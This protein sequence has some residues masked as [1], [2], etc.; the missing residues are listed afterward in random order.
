VNRLDIE[1]ELVE[2]L[3]RDATG[4]DALPLLAFTLQ[5]LFND[6]APE[7][8]LTL[9]HYD[10][11]G[12]IGGSIDRAL[13]EAQRKLGT[14]GSTESLRRL[15]VPGLA[16]W[17]PA[18]NAAKRLVAN[19]ADLTRGDRV[20]LKP[21]ANALVEGRLITRSRETLEVA[22]EALLR[23]APISGWLEEQKDALKLRDDVLKEAKEWEAAGRHDNDLVRSGL[24]LES[25]LALQDDADFAS[26]L[27]P[28]KDY[29]AACRRLETAGQRKA[30]RARALVM[31]LMLATIAGLQ[32]VIFKEPI[33][34]FFFE[35]TAVRHYIA[36]QV[37]PY[38]LTA[39]A[40][41]ALKPGA[42]FRECDSACP[43]MIVVPAGSFR[44]G[45]PDSEAGR[46]KD[47]EPV[48][49]VS[50]AKPFAVGKFELTWDDWDACVAMRGCDGRPTSDTA[51]G[52]GR[53]PLINVSWDQA[54][55]YVNWFSRMTGKPY[56]LLTEAEWEYAARAGTQTAYSFGNDPAEICRY[57]NGADQSF[58]RGGNNG[59]IAS[60]DDGQELTAPVGSYSP[61]AFGL[62]D[63]HG[64]V[65]EW[66]QDCYVDSYKEAPTDGSS[67]PDK[68]GCP[69]VIRGGSWYRDPLSLRSAIRY[70]YHPD[71]H[72]DALGFRL[73]RTLL[74]IP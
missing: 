35:Q 45:S 8:E 40:E 42:T 12:G 30:R 41:R 17:D 9:A 71:V 74:L 22:H 61:N 25:A 3:V 56:R 10:A 67:V 70:R 5:R 54:Q 47:E 20:A 49:T 36:E 28:A 63:M 34:N 16:T 55:A 62:Y 14:G 15:M 33:G 29:I 37:R 32:G 52:R 26:A 66:V 27:A 39:E 44:M 2:E 18:A 69:R 65:W 43:E 7:Q 38:V 58:R 51:Y 11:M 59:E 64:N 57:A 23:R 60:C 46:G 21:L 53:K 24:R 73:A 13:A 48:H 4:A 31:T 1:P 19:E 68:E 72:G 6:Y 50:I